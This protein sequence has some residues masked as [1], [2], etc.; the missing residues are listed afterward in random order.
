MRG[1]IKMFIAKTIDRHPK[2]CWALLVWWAMGCRTFKETFIED[3]VFHQSCREEEGSYCGKC[4][5]D[6]EKRWSF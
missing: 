3:N 1:K 5:E 2:A 4:K 6:A